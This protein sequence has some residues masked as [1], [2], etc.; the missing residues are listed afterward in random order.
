MI[1]E[2]QYKNRKKLK[3]WLLGTAVPVRGGAGGLVTVSQ[4]YTARN[5]L[6]IVKPARLYNMQPFDN[7]L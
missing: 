7:S 2:L 6:A 5:Q 3:S 1:N 4:E